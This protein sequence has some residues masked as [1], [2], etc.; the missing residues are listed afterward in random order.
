MTGRVETRRDVITLSPEVLDALVRVSDYMHART[1]SNGDLVCP[2]HGLDHTGRSARSIV[3]DCCLYAA[4][5]EPEYLRRAESRAATVA[6]RLIQDPDHGAWIYHPGRLDPANNSNNV[7]DSGECTDALSTL[8][9]RFGDEIDRDRRDTLVDAVT[10]NCQSYLV[11][12]VVSKEVTNQRLWGAAGL[13]A[14]FGLTGDPAWKAAVL[15]SVE[16]SI[17]DQNPDGSFPYH[18]CPARF[19]IHE[20]AAGVSVY[21]QPRVLAY[22][23]YALSLCGELE[24]FRKPLEAGLEFLRAA[25]TPLGYKPLAIESKRWFWAGDVEAGSHPYDIYALAAM[26][27]IASVRDE[28]QV[29]CARLLET[30][31]D[32]GAFRG[33]P[34]GYPGF[35]CRHFHTADVAWLARASEIAAIKPEFAHG[36]LLEGDEVRLFPDAGLVRIQT[37]DTCALISARSEPRNVLWG[38]SADHGEVFYLGRRARG[39]QNEAVRIG[40]DDY[41]WSSSG[42]RSLAGI[43]GSVLTINRPGRDLRFR[44]HVARSV[45]RSGRRRWAFSALIRDA[46]ALFSNA[47]GRRFRGRFWRKWNVAASAGGATMAGGMA[48][49]DGTPLEGVTIRRVYEID[50]QGLGVVESLESEASI[51]DLSYT[52]PDGVESLDVKTG[53]KWSAH[54][55]SL[56]FEAV[57]EP[58]SI[59]ISYRR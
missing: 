35:L 5:A 42:S 53:W 7:I 22:A 12:A 9:R 2:E 24:T 38:A 46:S 13:A 30:Q 50:E 57:D 31:D 32:D 51:A 11:D 1:S 33:V 59:S 34:S 18:P 36:A 23:A 26:L 10:K 41:G 48:E 49:I 44:A 20:G 8:I 58:E 19:G 25:S 27:G 21:Y 45:F 14:A 4:T 16:R 54:G 43:L 29:K 3:I 37:P 39:W 56:R 47:T 6:N 52:P 15:E 40:N 28:I 17:E 55:G